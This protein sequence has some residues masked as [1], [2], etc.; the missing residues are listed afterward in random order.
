MS[1]PTA[2][3]NT[4]DIYH[5][6]T[7]NA[8]PNPPDVSGVPCLLLPRWQDGQEKERSSPL[9]YTH[10]LFVD[11]SVDLRDRGRPSVLTFDQNETDAVYIPDQNGT[12]FW[13]IWVE[14]VGGCKRAFLERQWGSSVAWP[15][16]NL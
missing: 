8:P 15:T 12:K 14:K 10:I 13:V 16:N 4:C 1:L 7:F 3:N 2:A 9:W 6:A 11:L 5:R